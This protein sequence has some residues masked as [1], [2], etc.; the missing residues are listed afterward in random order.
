[1]NIQLVQ[2]KSKQL[3]KNLTMNNV[4]VLKCIVTVIDIMATVQKTQFWSLSYMNI[5]HWFFIHVSK[6][7]I[8][9]DRARIWFDIIASSSNHVLVLPIH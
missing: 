2:H 9:T 3:Q 6:C 4:N 7:N 5:F 8:V 1:M